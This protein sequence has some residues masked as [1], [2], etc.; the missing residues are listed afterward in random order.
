MATY[1]DNFLG[2]LTRG[3]IVAIKVT[4]SSQ[5][6]KAISS[7]KS[8][9]KKAASKKASTTKNTTT[10]TKTKKAPAKTAV[11]PKAKVTAKITKS[12]ETKALTSNV[13]SAAIVKS[14]T[15]L[16]TATRIIVKCD[17]GFSNLLYL[18]GEG[19]SLNWE[20]GIKMKN[21]NADEWI[22][23]TDK[24]FTT[25]EFKVLLNDDSYESGENHSISCGSSLEY[26]PS[27]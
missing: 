24:K 2:I 20:K 15:N 21:I 5:P 1:F 14:V 26:I 11:A 7:A 12:T 16:K 6:K 18:R 25:C 9:M 17:V 8:T 10:I 27:F 22:W 3:L 4:T 13:K 19:A 23:E